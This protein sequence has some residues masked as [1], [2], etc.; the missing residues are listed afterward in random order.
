MIEGLKVTLTGHK[1]RELCLA[2]A[3]HHDD[4]AQVYKNQIASM[5]SNLVE[6]A[7]NMT[8]GDPVKALQARQSTHENEAS[9]MRF[10]AD[11][12]ALGEEYLLDHSALQ[13]L[14]I[15]QSRY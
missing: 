7:E 5:Q 8:N 11:N 12:I 2:R 4:R 14:G 9:E 1:L 6:P 3:S 15:V 13:K 10:Y